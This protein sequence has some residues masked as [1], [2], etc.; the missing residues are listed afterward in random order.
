M[1]N[2]KQAKIGSVFVCCGKT[3]VGQHYKNVLDLESTPFNYVLTQEQ[4][5]LSSEQLKG[6]RKI[7]ND[8]FLQGYMAA[9]KENIYKY[10]VILVA[11]GR[12]I[13]EALRQ[14]GLPYFVVYPSS[15]CKEEYVL[16]ARNR[17]NAEHF[18]DRIASEFVSDDMLSD[19][20]AQH[21]VLG[22]GEYLEDLLL[23]LKLINKKDKV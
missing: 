8:K 7:K 14:N 21:Y 6:T 15:D 19:S 13:R 2:R 22:K 16:R 5:K 23:R 9:V 12:S 4:K 10:D 18:V 3:Y 1:N 20:W 17:G 11:P